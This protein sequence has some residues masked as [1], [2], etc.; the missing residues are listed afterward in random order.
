MKNLILIFA[1]VAIAASIA[2]AEACYP[3]PD[4]SKAENDRLM[5]ECEAD[6]KKVENVERERA[7]K[8][9]KIRNARSEECKTYA[10]EQL[11]LI[12]VYKD[13]LITQHD[14][15]TQS[16]VATYKFMQ[17]HTPVQIQGW[18]SLKEYTK[19]QIKKCDKVH[20][21]N[22]DWCDATDRRT[23]DDIYSSIDK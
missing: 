20:E 15:E 10:R 4:L 12:Y 2:T 9:M 23:Q 13:G 3:F 11:E 19:E 5:R 6:N 17:G 1:T 16:C 22:L 7:E 21:L 14:Y 8:L 18:V